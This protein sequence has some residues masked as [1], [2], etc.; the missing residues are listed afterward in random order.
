MPGRHE[1]AI[2]AKSERV[3]LTVIARKIAHAAKVAPARPD[4][5][6]VADPLIAD[7]L[8]ILA[9]WMSTDTLK[10]HTV[11]VSW[12][13]E[14]PSDLPPCIVSAKGET[15]S[16]RIAI[17]TSDHFSSLSA[18]RL[19][20]LPENAD[21]AT[22]EPLKPFM[23]QN[24]S[25]LGLRLTRGTAFQS[26]LPDR[27]IW[28]N[29]TA[30][31]LGVLCR[32]L[33][34]VRIDIA[35]AEVGSPPS[36]ITIMATPELLGLYDECDED[37]AETD[38]NPVLSPRLGPCEVEI[39]AVADR[40]R[41]SVADCS[42]LEIGQ[43]VSLPGLRFDQLELNIAMNEGRIP[44]VDAALGADK[45]RKAVRLNRGL[46]PAFRLPPMPDAA[47]TKRSAA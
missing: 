38:E 34:I 9:R 31:T 22:L 26:R 23:E 11:Q 40:I 42:R 25:D 19:L 21:A 41:M 37:A 28:T 10:L 24:L 12:I 35:C 5:D 39:K 17:A 29:E 20:S 47:P 6:S 15:S 13:S 8:P 3:V 2:K 7:I 43:I 32:D 44:L 33:E 45:G 27:V 30:E 14:I 16:N 46:D 18:C 36:M 4:A 1:N